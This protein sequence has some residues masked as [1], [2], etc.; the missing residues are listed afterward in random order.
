MVNEMAGRI[1]AGESEVVLFT[2]SEAN[3]TLKAATRASLELNWTDTADLE[4]EDRG[5]GPRLLNR[6]EVKHGLVLRAP[7]PSE[8]ELRQFDAANIELGTDR[9]DQ[10][11]LLLRGAVGAGL[12][13][14]TENAQ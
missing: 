8:A 9:P 14:P 5:P 1:H 4:F 2:G 7:I 12:C 6:T 13:Q 3:R 10:R 11:P